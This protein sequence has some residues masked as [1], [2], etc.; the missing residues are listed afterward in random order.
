MGDFIHL[1]GDILQ[2][3]GAKKVVSCVQNQAVIE[4]EKNTIIIGGSEIEVKKLNLE[5][6]EVSLQGNFSNIK[7]AAGKEKKVPF[8]KR[9]FK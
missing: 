7:F 4:C 6:G 1:E 5:E 8:F 2:I 3:K 9:I